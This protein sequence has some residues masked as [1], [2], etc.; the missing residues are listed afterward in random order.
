MKTRYWI[1]VIIAIA[2][3]LRLYG[4][5]WG[6]TV[7]DEVFY[8]FRAIGLMDFDE[9][10]DQT[11]PLEWFDPQIPSWTKLSFHDH[12]PLVFWIQHFSILIFGENNFALR[13]PSAIL[14]IISVY[15]LYLLGRRL[16][17]ESAGLIA[18]GLMA[19]TLNSVYISRTGMQEPY[20]IFFILLTIYLFLL[21][22]EKEK[23]LIWLGAA[24][25]LGFLAKYNLFILGPIFL[26][27]LLF[28][29]RDYF[30]N[31]KLWI[32]ALLALAI[33]SPVIIYNFKLYQAVGHFDFQFSYI[34]KQNPD[35]WKV[36]PGKNIGTLYERIRDFL[37]RMLNTHSWLFLALFAVS[38]IAG[39]KSFFTRRKNFLTE[40]SLLL[41]T[42]VYLVFLLTLIGPSYRFLTILTP[43]M[44]L[45]VAV[46]LSHL[47]IYYYA[48]IAIA[49]FEIFYSA[50]NQITH[51]P[52][53][54]STI[55]GINASPWF[56]SKVRYE[57][58]NWGYNALGDFFADEFKGKI[59]AIRFD[60]R[61]NFIEKT[62]EKFI[63]K[64][65]KRGFK[66]Y[67]AIVVTYGNFDRGAKLWVLDR[68]HIYHGW[69]IIDLETYFKYLDENG[70]DYYDRVGF[71]NYYFVLS[72]NI[73]PSGEFQAL[74]KNIQPI[75]VLNPRGEEAFKVYKHIRLTFA[76]DRSIMDFTSESAL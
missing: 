12:P 47:S 1:I 37:P 3:F 7:N 10:A 68:L 2:A 44:A 73:V 15:I 8:G 63:D 60:A 23:Y 61:Y 28:F 9:A 41:I 67:S 76:P 75:S 42:F 30:W 66:P 35:V 11:T 43:F 48:L 69:P 6:D 24:L 49:L 74:T 26:T 53:D 17:S 51:Y 33:F 29:K 36:A 70:Q 4:L 27:Y 13:F 62:Q 72:S 20:V 54:P 65:L 46:L 52:L 25:G 57:N 32:G 45:G 18:S 58:Y 38:F 22:L 21:A 50:N 64:D 39:L 59:P 71:K 19:V 56:S 34:F 55:L 40:N 31:K 5:S 14:G 16:Y